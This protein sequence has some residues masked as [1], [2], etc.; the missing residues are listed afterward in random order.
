MQIN[1]FF[2]KLEVLFKPDNP[3][4]VAQFESLLESFSNAVPYDYAGCYSDIARVGFSYIP[5]WDQIR[6]ICENRIIK[7]NQI[8]ER[9]DGRFCCIACQGSGNVSKLAGYYK[10]CPH[11]KGK[12]ISKD[13]EKNEFIKYV[14]PDEAL[15]TLNKILSLGGKDGSLKIAKC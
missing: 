15:E 2:K 11:C 7:K 6:N 9:T 4:K 10:T 1:E 8:D 5:G 13:S 14:H 12:G 3:Q